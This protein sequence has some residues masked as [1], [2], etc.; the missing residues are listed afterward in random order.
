LT[1]LNGWT[2]LISNRPIYRSIKMSA[3]E[4]DRLVRAFQKNPHF[5]DEFRN[6]AG[7]PEHRLQWAQEKGFQLTREE[8]ERLSDSNQVLSDDDLEQ[9]AGGDDGWGTG[10]GGTGTTGGGG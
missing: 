4:F 7:N 9:V 3:A 6:L 10:T 2:T 8:L 1:D 5:L